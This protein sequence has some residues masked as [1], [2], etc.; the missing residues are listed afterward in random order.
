MRSR[1][2]FGL[3]GL[4]VVSTLLLSLYSPS[5]SAAEAFEVTY[6][7]FPGR[8]ATSEQILV[9]VRA[10]H[11]NPNEPMW[12]Y[13]FWDSRCIAMRQADVLV[14]KIHQNR[15]DITF[16]PPKDLCAKGTHDIWIWVED[17][18]NMIVKKYW[19]Y[20]IT[21]VVPQLDWFD[22]LTQTELNAIGGPT[23][24]TGP[25]GSAGPTGAT[26]KQGVPG[27]A[28]AEGATG[29]AGPQGETGEQGPPGPKGQRGEVG[30]DGKDAPMGLFYIIGG[31]SVVSIICVILL[32][33]RGK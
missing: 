13:V 20:S 10:F 16:Y 17:S 3:V 19:S 2:G 32:F 18:A 22:E 14:N 23:G 9:F 26:G 5:V 24:A 27:A 28:G 15:W 6:N 21:N 8:G 25:Q 33:S 29:P 4:A 11:D 1:I 31:L 12:I 7:V 30:L